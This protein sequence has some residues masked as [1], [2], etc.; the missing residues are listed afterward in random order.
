MKS[1]NEWPLLDKEK[2]FG[3]LSGNSYL[4]ERHKL[5]YVATPKVACT[6]LKWWFADLEGCAQAI[7]QSGGSAESDPELAIHDTFHKVAPNVTGLTPSALLEPLTSAAY[8]RFAIVR[9]PYKR[10]FSAW[11]SKLLLREPL[12]TT[13]YLQSD[14]F[15]QPIKSIVDLSEAFE[16][17]LE[18]L[19]INEAPDYWD[20]H[21]TPQATLLRPDLVNY[22]KV[23][24]IENAD[25]LSAALAEWL[26]PQFI[27]PFATRSA[28]ESLIPYLPEL[29][30]ARS[31]ELIR[32]LYAEDFAK[33]GYSTQ[34]PSAKESF[35]TD[36][37]N[38]AIK[39]IEIL[40]GR[41]Q[42]LGELSVQI[43]AHKQ[44]MVQKNRTIAEQ[45]A[46]IGA[47]YSSHSW[48]LTRPLRYSAKY[49]R[50]LKYTLIKR[51]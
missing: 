18:H 2:L 30:T 24:Q 13:P 27:D 37:F 1:L 23:V 51:I 36:Q 43:N 19:A 39:A 47:I 10:I 31:A 6:S 46:V 29:I 42:R 14:F 32:L 12:Q 11:Q 26:G 41:H 28:N 49:L 17:F 15:N 44:A 50:K 22:S 48:R 38:L 8:F 9:N 5:L 35:S 16:G 20:V 45:D 25:V 34:L 7:R 4:S 21:W 33:F 40:R 3:Y